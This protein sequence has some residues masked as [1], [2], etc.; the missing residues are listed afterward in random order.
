MTDEL[1]TAVRDLPKAMPFLHVPA[2]HGADSVLKRMRRQYSVAEY[3]DLVDRIYAT[4]PDAAITS[5]FIVGFCGETEEEFQ[6]TAD[7][8]RYCRFK[9]SFIFKYSPRKGTKSA[10]LFEDDVPESVKRRRNNELLAVQ[11]EICADQNDHLIGRKVE[12]LVEGA[13][14]NFK[15]NATPPSSS[16]WEAL[17]SPSR[18]DYSEPEGK[19]TPVEKGNL[20]PLVSPEELSVHGSDG[21]GTR[22]NDGKGGGER[23]I[24]LTGRTPGDRIVVFDGPESLIGSFQTMEIVDATPFTLFGKRVDE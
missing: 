7:L 10:E 14:K 24:Q 20:L 4:I 22:E 2:Q 16:A 21:K 1:L 9:N 11:N 17:Q 18:D 3:R 6:Q 5:D 23:V 13:S 8:I 19:E 12:I 15:K